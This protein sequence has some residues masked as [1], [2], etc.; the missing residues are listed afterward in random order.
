[1]TE[2]EK[3][4]EF[5]KSA[6]RYFSA[7]CFNRVWELLDAPERSAADERRMLETAHAS[8]Y[9]WLERDDGGDQEISI[10]L[11]Q[12]SRVH[13]VLGNAEAATRYADD[14]IEISEAAPLAPFFLGFAYEAAAR[15]AKAAGDAGRMESCLA[16]ARDFAG[17]VP[18]GEERDL[19]AKDLDE[20]E[21]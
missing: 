2:D 4:A 15:A 19:L 9:H 16:K 13:S 14:C 11:W 5:E 7:N 3:R 1:M 17:Q 20:V 6:H 18:E 10:G 21:S 12:I 8:L